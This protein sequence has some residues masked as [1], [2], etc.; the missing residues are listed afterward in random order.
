MF[1]S[2]ALPF[3]VYDYQAFLD[4]VQKHITF[5]CYYEQLVF[6]CQNQCN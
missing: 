5:C 6:C 2:E 4:N 3:S 1:F